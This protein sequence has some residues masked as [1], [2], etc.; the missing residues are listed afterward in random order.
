MDCIVTAIR[1]RFKRR[2][3]SRGSFSCI[4]ARPRA[5]AR[6]R[7][8]EQGSRPG[9]TAAAQAL[10]WAPA[11]ASPSSVNRGVGPGVLNLSNFVLN[12]SKF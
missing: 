2:G 1:R 5:V 6:A 3:V 9:A 8:N 10:S 7:E 4:R 11:P 12:L